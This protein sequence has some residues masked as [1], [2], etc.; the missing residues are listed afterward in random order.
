MFLSIC[1][2]FTIADCNIQ[3]QM[4]PGLETSLVLEVPGR[5]VE[6]EQ[7]PAWAAYVG[8]SNLECHQYVLAHSRVHLSQAGE[9]ELTFLCERY[10]QLFARACPLLCELNSLLLNRQKETQTFQFTFCKIPAIC[11]L[12]LAMQI[13]VNVWA[14]GLLESSAARQSNTCVLRRVCIPLHPTTYLQMHYIHMNRS[15]PRSDYTNYMHLSSVLH[16][17][18]LRLHTDSQP[19]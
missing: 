19:A 9:Y 5:I 1:C 17:I 11:T 12:C 4:C 14:V 8:I 6:Q 16:V 13:V 18:S 3:V 2:I 15:S 10:L 7:G